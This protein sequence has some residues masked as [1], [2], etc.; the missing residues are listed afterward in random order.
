MFCDM[1]DTHI[2]R[3]VFRYVNP[4]EKSGAAFS[5]KTGLIERNGSYHNSYNSLYI[6]FPSSEKQREVTNSALSEERELRRL[7]F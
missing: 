5:D 6:T 1:G 7:T 2:I 4:T 3:G